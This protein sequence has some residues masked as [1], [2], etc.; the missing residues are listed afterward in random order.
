MVGRDRIRAPLATDEQLMV[1]SCAGLTQF[2]TGRSLCELKLREV[3]RP[4]PE[5]DAQGD[6]TCRATPMARIVAEACLGDGVGPPHGSYIML[7][8]RNSIHFRHSGRPDRETER[9]L[10][11]QNGPEILVGPSSFCVTLPFA[12][13]MPR[14]GVKW[15]EEREGCFRTYVRV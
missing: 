10:L 2:A 8:T 1:G 14:D 15:R 12:N 5:T 9:L 11:R 3:V 4:S 7:R 13:T 6:A